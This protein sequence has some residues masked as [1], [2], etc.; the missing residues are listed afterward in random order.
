MADWAIADRGL[1]S[2]TDG[3]KQVLLAAAAAAGCGDGSSVRLVARMEAVLVCCVVSCIPPALV[4][5]ADGVIGF[6]ACAGM[7]D[8]LGDVFLVVDWG[9]SHC[10]CRRFVSRIGT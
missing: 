6:A 3:Q 4:Q 1:Q 2:A 5:Q 10:V 9:S 7:K 8:Q